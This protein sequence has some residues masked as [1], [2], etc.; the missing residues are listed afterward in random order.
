[1]GCSGVIENLIE[2]L[3]SVLNL[4]LHGF[5]FIAFLR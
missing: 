4:D 1:M 3:T 5:S 2:N